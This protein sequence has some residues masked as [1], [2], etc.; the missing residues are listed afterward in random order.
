MRGDRDVGFARN[1]LAG[2]RAREER[3]G[4]RDVFDQRNAEPQRPPLDE[5]RR[6][7][8]G[9]Y[10]DLRHRNLAAAGRRARPRRASGLTTT[11]RGFGRRAQRAAQPAR[12]ALARRRPRKTGSPSLCLRSRLSSSNVMRRRRRRFV[13]SINS[14]EPARR[15]SPPRSR[16]PRCARSARTFAPRE[17]AGAAAPSR[18]QRSPRD[19]KQRER[20]RCRGSERFERR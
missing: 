20:E 7:V 17:R 16:R 15:P 5:L 14:I 10:E 18:G 8:R 6:F 9:A 4:Q 11:K 12:G 1:G 13:R 2:S 19:R 3:A